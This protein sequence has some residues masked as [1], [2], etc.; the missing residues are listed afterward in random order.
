MEITLPKT[1][2][3]SELIKSKRIS[4]IKQMCEKYNLLHFQLVS[5][6]PTPP[7]LIKSKGKA[8]FPL[9]VDKK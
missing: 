4:K 2:L 1:D 9:I 8:R 3:H 5:L 7:K 6:V